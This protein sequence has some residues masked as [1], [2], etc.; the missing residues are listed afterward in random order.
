MIFKWVS[1]IWDNVQYKLR[2][3]E[4]LAPI[5]TNKLNFI[6]SVEDEYFMFWVIHLI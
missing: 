1:I 5:Y 4:V 3:K 2:T 6:T